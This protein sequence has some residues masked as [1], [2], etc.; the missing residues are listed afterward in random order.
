MVNKSKK[1]SKKKSSKL[2]HAH[3]LHIIY[4]VAIIA[5]LLFL[6]FAVVLYGTATGEAYKTASRAR[7]AYYGT[8]S[9][10]STV[11]SNSRESSIKTVPK[12]PKITALDT[13]QNQLGVLDTKDMQAVSE[14]KQK[15]NALGGLGKV[16]VKEE[17]CDECATCYENDDG[18]DFMV[19]SPIVEITNAKVSGTGQDE[20]I[21]GSGGS[22]ALIKEYYCENGKMTMKMGKCADTGAGTSCNKEKTACA[23]ECT[24]KTDCGM[25]EVCLDSQCANVYTE[26]KCTGGNM[27]EPGAAITVDNNV[28]GEVTLSFGGYKLTKEDVKGVSAYY[29]MLV[30]KF[31]YPF[32][33]TCVNDEQIS[34]MLCS[35]NWGKAFIKQKL[36]KDLPYN[37]GMFVIDDKFQCSDGTTCFEGACKKSLA[38]TIS[39]IPKISNNVPIS[40]K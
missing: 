4:G 2:Q 38:S 40:I 8:T 24:K 7:A 17:I 12:I 23:P 13:A 20:C 28:Q 34:E 37:S 10:D 30:T 29:N 19:G 1:S 15:F 5:V 18:L 39:K 21:P 35:N 22:G 14:I 9:S 32:K 26:L 31:D 11:E 3:K 6:V 25:Y 36:G 27:I 16:M 33:D